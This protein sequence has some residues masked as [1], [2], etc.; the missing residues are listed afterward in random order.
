MSKEN[1]N[2]KCKPQLLCCSI[3]NLRSQPQHFRSLTELLA[4]LLSFEW[5]WIGCFIYIYGQ[6]VDSCS[7]KIASSF[8]TLIWRTLASFIEQLFAVLTF[9]KEQWWLIL[10]SGKIILDLLTIKRWPWTCFCIRVHLQC[11]TSHCFNTRRWQLCS[12]NPV[13]LALN[14]HVDKELRYV[15]PSF[16]YKLISVKKAYSVQ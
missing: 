16:S 4:T 5:L 1:A 11:L 8:V 3:N 2:L 14:E 12:A 10:A 9:F 6:V 15:T 7:A 13:G